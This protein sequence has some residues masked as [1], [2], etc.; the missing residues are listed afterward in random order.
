MKRSYN[1][2]VRYNWNE[3]VPWVQTCHTV[4]EVGCY[5]HSS[6]I[7]T[8]PSIN[9]F[10]RWNCAFCGGVNRWMVSDKPPE[11]CRSCGAPERK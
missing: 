1:E 10:P 3:E 6:S 11:K 2:I 4:P 8:M 9:E 7:V 5:T